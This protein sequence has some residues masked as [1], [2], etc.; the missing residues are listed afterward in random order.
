V[1]APFQG[2]KPEEFRRVIEVNLIGQA[3]GAMA[4]LPHLK[5]A[6]GGALILIGSVESKLSFPFHS[7]YSASKHGMIGFID[8]LRMELMH[9]RTPISVTTI[10]PA[11]IN[12]PF[13]DKTLT[14]LGVKPRPAPPIYEPVLVAE[15]VLHAAEHPVREIY[16]GGAGKAIEWLHLLSPSL[17]DWLVSRFGYRPQLTDQPKTDQAPNNLYHHIEGYDRVKGDFSKEA[18]SISIF[19]GLELHPR[20]RWG[21]LGALVGAGLILLRRHKS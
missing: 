18:R 6:G 12:T 9:D 16:V 20:L 1:Y 19:A 11:G 4:A 2:T 5:R 21:L 13:F 10:L 17:T 15:A 8:A 7:A 3:F 14:R